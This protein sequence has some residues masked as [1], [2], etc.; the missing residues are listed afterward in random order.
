MRVLQTSKHYKTRH[1]CAASM[2]L[3]NETRVS[4]ERK[5]DARA[6]THEDTPA[7]TRAP[8]KTVCGDSQ[9]QSIQIT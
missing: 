5:D 7:V 3:A 8:L 6:Y 2:H 4:F 9:Q 1:E